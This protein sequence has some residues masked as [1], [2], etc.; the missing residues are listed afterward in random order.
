MN[1]SFEKSLISVNGKPLISHPGLVFPKHVVQLRKGFRPE[2]G[3][4]YTQIPKGGITTREVANLMGCSLSGARQYLHRHKTRFALIR[5]KDGSLESFWDKKAVLGLLQSRNPTVLHA[6][7]DYYSTSETIS[8]LGMA[9]SAL[10]R[11]SRKGLLVEKKV[12]IRST[13]GMRIKCYYLK[14]SVIRTARKRGKWSEDARK[15]D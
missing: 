6:P 3:K 10:Y 2:T 8:I 1:L 15:A 14:S 11:L 12:R 13:R 7:R 4:A 9:R 5:R